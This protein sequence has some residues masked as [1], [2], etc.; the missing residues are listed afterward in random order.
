MQW[1]ILYVILCRV[2][3]IPTR[4]I[5]AVAAALPTTVRV[6]RVQRSEQSEQEEEG[7]AEVE[8]N[9]EV[10]DGTNVEPEGDE[11]ERHSPVFDFSPRSPALT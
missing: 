5:A 1:R 10:A 8:G 6:L 9:A 2:P 4:R 11:A 3:Y 7:E